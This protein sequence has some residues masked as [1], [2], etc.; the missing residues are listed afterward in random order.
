[1]AKCYL[2]ADTTPTLQIKVQSRCNIGCLYSD[3]SFLILRE[4]ANC[5]YIDQDTQVGRGPKTFFSASIFPDVTYTLLQFAQLEK[6]MGL[7][8]FATH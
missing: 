7:Y 1:M 5:M 2:K 6:S 3:L 4:A 8:R